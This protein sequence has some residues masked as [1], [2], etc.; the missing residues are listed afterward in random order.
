[1]AITVSS[2]QKAHLLVLSRHEDGHF[3]WIF[4]FLGIRAAK[5]KAPFALI[6]SIN[7]KGD[8]PSGEPR[9]R[10]IL[11]PKASGNFFLTI[12]APFWHHLFHKS[13]SLKLL[14]PLSPCAPNPLM[15]KYVVKNRFPQNPGSGFLIPVYRDP[16][17]GFDNCVRE[18]T[19]CGIPSLR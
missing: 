10:G 8:G 12:S 17:K 11:V 5:K 14:S 15:V 7:A 9:T 18:A 1:M 4:T 13:C 6:V 3:Y 2:K 16:S 19:A